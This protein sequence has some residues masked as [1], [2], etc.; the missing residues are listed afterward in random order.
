MGK[1]E[2][3]FCNGVCVDCYDDGIDTELAALR[4]IAKFAKLVTDT[5]ELKVYQGDKMELLEALKLVE[6]I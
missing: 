5:W 4:R 6:I 3:H 1:R 2:E